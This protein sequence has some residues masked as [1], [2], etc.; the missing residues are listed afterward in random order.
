MGLITSRRLG[1]AVR[2]NRVRRLLREAVR[3]CETMVP[4]GCDTV[5]IGR[6]GSLNAK[7]P[8]VEQGVRE[9]LRRAFGQRDSEQ[10][11]L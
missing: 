8:E 1:K 7:L 5:W 4:Q 3:R 2:R 9:L 6:S 11:S 10:L